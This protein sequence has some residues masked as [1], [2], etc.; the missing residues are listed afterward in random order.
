MQHV[1]PSES[2]DPAVG[3][4]VAMR[5]CTW[6][7]IMSMWGAH[8]KVKLTGMDLKFPSRT[9][10]CN[11]DMTITPHLS[12]VL[13]LWTPEYVFEFSCLN[14]FVLLKMFQS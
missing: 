10:L 1:N 6:C 4:G 11:N 13:M 5:L 3:S 8:F 12:L 9:L 14:T 7:T 2:G